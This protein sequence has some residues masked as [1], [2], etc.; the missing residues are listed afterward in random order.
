MGFTFY[1][2]NPYRTLGLSPAANQKEIARRVS[3][4]DAYDLVGKIPAFKNDFKSLGDLTRTKLDI[5]DAK[6]KIDDPLNRLYEGIFWVTDEIEPDLEALFKSDIGK[7]ALGL[8][9]LKDNERK[10]PADENILNIES[11][12]NQTVLLHAALLG[13]KGT[14]SA[15]LVLSDFQVLWKELNGRWAAS[16]NRPLFWKMLQER[17]RSWNDPRLTEQGINAVIARAKERLL[18][19][20]A[21]LCSVKGISVDDISFRYIVLENL[22]EVIGRELRDRSSIFQQRNEAALVACKKADD[23][24]EAIDKKLSKNEITKKCLEIESVFLEECQPLVMKPRDAKKVSEI[25]MISDRC[26]ESLRTIAIKIWNEGDRGEEA[27]RISMAAESWATSMSLKSK[28]QNERRNI[29][30]QVRYRDV[31]PVEVAPTLSLTNGFGFGIYFNHDQDSDRDL[32]RTTY[33]FVM[34]FIPIYPIRD[35]WVRQVG[36]GRWQFFGST[37]VGLGNQILRGIVISTVAFCIYSVY[38]ESSSSRPN[39]NYNSVAAQSYPAQNNTAR[40]SVS[41]DSLAARK[42][43]LLK[44]WSVIE[45][46]ANELKNQDEVIK[47]LVSQKK[48]MEAVYTADTIP[49]EEAERY[50]GLLERLRSMIASYNIELKRENRLYDEYKKDED[51]YNSEVKLRNEGG[52]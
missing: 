43:G 45:A 33:Y 35:Y 52:Y 3:E 48:S 9:S 49:P 39:Y 40:N 17:C 6:Q 7:I 8:K 34:L 51:S 14:S 37:R 29:H 2:K 5:R 25:D 21:E 16:L 44:R 31:T 26:A 46:M 23:E 36:N 13:L 15:G 30:N 28:L 24:V 32:Y 12:H 22:E 50:N 42:A 20:Q 41:Q 11:Y 27:V 18:L 19:C 1:S 47:N 38:G 10:V 4:F